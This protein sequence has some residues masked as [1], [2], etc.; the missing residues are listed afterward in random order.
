MPPGH[1]I[2]KIAYAFARK[3]RKDHN[4]RELREQSGI[5]VEERI[6]LSVTALVGSIIMIGNPHNIF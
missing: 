2:Q 3:V 5:G 1:A 6:I 4:L